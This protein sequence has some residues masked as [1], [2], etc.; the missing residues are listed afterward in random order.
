MTYQRIKENLV[1]EQKAITEKNLKKLVIRLALFILGAILCLSFSV[2]K[3]LGLFATLVVILGGVFTYS[4][5]LDY[6]VEDTKNIK[7][8]SIISRLWII[9]P[10]VFVVLYLVFNYFNF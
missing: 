1:D 8:V 7:K 3:L 5:L 2:Y 10:I 6:C 4:C 9:F